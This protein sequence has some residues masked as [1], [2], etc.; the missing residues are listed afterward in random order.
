MIHQYFQLKYREVH[1][2]RAFSLTWPASMLIYWNKRKR[3]HEKRIQLPE[4][5][6][7]T[8]TWPLFLC[9][10]TPIWP[11]WVMWKRSIVLPWVIRAK[12]R[13][14]RRFVLEFKARYIF[15]NSYVWCFL[16]KKSNFRV[17]RNSILN[18]ECKEV[19]DQFLEN[20]DFP[21]HFL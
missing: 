9:F 20:L 13:E 17:Q 1:A 10:G 7:G 5:F 2:Y 21:I 15:L 11:P 18:L 12:W 6:L 3:L 14:I 8:P 4:D 16:F 19:R